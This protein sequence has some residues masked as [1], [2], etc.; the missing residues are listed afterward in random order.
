MST[1]DLIRPSEPVLP[2][3]LVQPIDL[4]PVIAL[5]EKTTGLVWFLPHGE[6]AA[7]RLETQCREID[8][9][10]GRPAYCYA[11]VGELAADECGYDIYDATALADNIPPDWAFDRATVTLA[12]P[13]IGCYK[14]LG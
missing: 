12:A 6:E 14:R 1:L 4:Q 8:R 5:V 11:R 7:P 9:V 13:R 3:E 2:G 10:Y